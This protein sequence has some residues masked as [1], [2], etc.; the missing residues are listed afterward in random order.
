MSMIEMHDSLRWLSNYSNYV[1]F[2]GISFLVAIQT[3]NVWINVHMNIWPVFFVIGSVVV[4]QFHI[5]KLVMDIKLKKLCLN[6]NE[7]IFS[8]YESAH[9]F[10]IFATLYFA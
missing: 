10:K 6:F 4:L 3:D 7:A 8:L 1:S 9:T 2:V 5:A